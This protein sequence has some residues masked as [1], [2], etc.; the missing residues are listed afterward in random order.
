[1][2]IVFKENSKLSKMLLGNK[3]IP[4]III[5]AFITIVWF[6]GLIR[7]K[8]SWFDEAA[9]ASRAVNFAENNG[10]G[11]AFLGDPPTAADVFVVD[12]VLRG[13]WFK[14][15]GAGILQNRI[16]NA[17]CLAGACILFYI[18]CGFLGISIFSRI[19]GTCLLSLDT[20]WVW[21]IRTGRPDPTA[22]LFVALAFFCSVRI[23]GNAILPSRKVGWGF[24]CGISIALSLVTHSYSIPTGFWIFFFLL[25]Y[26]ST[27]SFSKKERRLIFA[28]L[29]L[30]GLFI[31]FGYL[32][33]L[34][35][36]G[37]KIAYAFQSSRQ[38]ISQE[39]GKSIPVLETLIAEFNRWLRGSLIMVP[40]WLLV[41]YA[42]KAGRRKSNSSIEKWVVFGAGWIIVHF[43]G[44]LVFLPKHNWY[45]VSYVAIPVCLLATIAVDQGLKEGANFKR[46]LIVRLGIAAVA[47]NFML[48]SI[49]PI[50]AI[51]QWHE[52]SLNGV[53][54]DF[55]VHIPR[56]SK[57][58]CDFNPYLALCECGFRPFL[59]NPLVIPYKDDEKFKIRYFDEIIKSVRYVIF[60]HN[61]KLLEHFSEKLQYIT[62]VGASKKDYWWAKDPPVWFD[63]FRVKRKS[64]E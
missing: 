39:A 44:C 4:I 30:G 29:T 63:I 61:D 19:L 56:D 14:V 60:C 37:H 34:L 58:A 46:R 43:I 57:I 15:V 33:Y 22:L 62:T 45:P 20:S 47:W 41:F 1:M 53:K 13:L 40:T 2:K 17:I 64:F 35:T 16:F 7:C 24:V 52:R 25:T 23:L 11:M 36:N 3:K 55:I 26:L 50:T 10:I 54:R 8:T 21:F 59:V 6:F 9:Y 5:A 51:L 18:S 32:P 42:I 38:Y 27:S 28:S 12:P 48:A 49:Y 31:F